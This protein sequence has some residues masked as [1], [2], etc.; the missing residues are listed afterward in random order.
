MFGASRCGPQIICGRIICHVFA[1]NSTTHRNP[2]TL[3]HSMRSR[4]WVVMLM[5]FKLAVCPPPLVLGIAFISSLSFK[6]S[7]VDQWLI[8]ISLFFSRLFS[9][10]Y[11]IAIQALPCNEQRESKIF[12]IFLFLFF[13]KVNFLCFLFFHNEP[14]STGSFFVHKHIAQIQCGTKFICLQN[15]ENKHLTVEGAAKEF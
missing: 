14:P 3:F 5:H 2:P 9:D 10:G 6:N 15:N 8:A 13:S 1:E 11:V 4:S 7:M 12:S